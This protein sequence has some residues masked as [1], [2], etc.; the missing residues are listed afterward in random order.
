[1]LYDRYKK[2]F[3]LNVGLTY[4]DKV[5]KFLLNDNGM[6]HNKP[7]IWIHNDYEVNSRNWM[8]FYSRNT[9][10]INQPYL[11]LCIESLIKNCSETFN[12]CL[13]DDNSF[14]ALLSDWSVDMN[15]LS[16]PI[17]SHYR[18]LGMLKLLYNYGGIRLPSSTIVMNDMRMFANEIYN[19]CFVGELI[20]KNSSSKYSLF[21]PDNEIMG[22]N[23][24]CVI[25]HELVKYMEMKIS[26]DSTNEMDFNGDLNRYIYKLSLS[27]KIKVLDGMIFGVKDV[28]GHPIVIDDLMSSS[29]VNFCNNLQMLYVPKKEILNRINYQWFSRLSKKQVLEANTVISK[30]LLVSLGRCSI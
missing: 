4:E 11:S 10:E 17:K 5:K 12:I 16:D 7:I 28:N 2:K 1:M 15:I 27:N 8:S 6:L 26:K 18:L 22:C 23:K 19:G 29:K 3:G 20:N 14:K 13:I 25:M 24:N 9:K 30:K 21:Y